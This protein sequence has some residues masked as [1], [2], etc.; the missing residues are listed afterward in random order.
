MCYLRSEGGRKRLSH[1]Q[2]SI[3]TH[4]PCEAELE[5]HRVG[6]AVRVGL[7]YLEGI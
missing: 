2:T 1:A 6:E 3:V 4:R 5:A 7:W